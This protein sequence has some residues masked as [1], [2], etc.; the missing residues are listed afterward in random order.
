MPWALAPF[1]DKEKLAADAGT[2]R[3]STP[4]R[5]AANITVMA[6]IRSESLIGVR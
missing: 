2:A 4:K 3:P 5:Q 1:S 6:F